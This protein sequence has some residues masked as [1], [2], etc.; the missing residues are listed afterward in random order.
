MGIDLYA[1]KRGLEA[2]S[3]HAWLQR[4]R[5]ARYE[6]EFLAHRSPT[7]NLYRG[8]YGSFAQAQ[9]SVPAARAD[10]YDN[11]PSAALYRDR[12]RRVFLNDYP[13]M[14]WLGKLFDAGRRSVFDLGGHIGLAYYAYQRYLDYPAGLSWQVHDMPAVTAAGLA[15]AQQHD[16]SGWLSFSDEPQQASGKDIFFAAGSLQYLDYSLLELLAGLAQPPA[17]LLLNS[18]PI[19]PTASY[20]TVQNM[21]TACCPYR[22]TAE[23]EFIDG[24]KARGYALHD[25][26]ENQQRA[27][28]IP[29]HPE[30]SLDRYF[31]FYFVRQE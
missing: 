1:G 29:F 23:R 13:T 20:F 24:L 5:E 27:C 28:Q 7:K 6:R 22:V 4:W 18:V 8:V 2:V 3:R 31:G 26:W 14:L 30:Y 10:S 9:A 17:H 16:A 25:R 11:E 19:H 12:T 21:G 15:W